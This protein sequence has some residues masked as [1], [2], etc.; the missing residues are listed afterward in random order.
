[1][2]DKEEDKDSEHAPVQDQIQ[3]NLRALYGETLSEALPDKLLDLLKQLESQD[4]QK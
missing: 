2:A 4:K 3:E 1:M